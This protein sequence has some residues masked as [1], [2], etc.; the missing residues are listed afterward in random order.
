[1]LNGTFRLPIPTLNVIYRA[2]VR[3]NPNSL[4]LAYA[5]TKGQGACWQNCRVV[6][7]LSFFEQGWCLVSTAEASVLWQKS[8]TACLHRLTK[9]MPPPHA[10]HPRWLPAHLCCVQYWALTR[11]SDELLPQI[12]FRV[13]GLLKP[14]EIHLYVTGEKGAFW[15]NLVIMWWETWTLLRKFIRHDFM[16]FYFCT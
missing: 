11:W 16:L 10:I 14:S 5:E 9:S 1:M 13:T 2:D 8:V 3:T 4:Q 12:D 15:W 6:Q 7:S